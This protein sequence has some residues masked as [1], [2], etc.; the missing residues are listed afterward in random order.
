[1]HVLQHYPVV[2]FLLRLISVQTK[3]RIHNLPNRK[4]YRY[5]RPICSINLS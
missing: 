3:I 2:A 5:S 4:L 1:V